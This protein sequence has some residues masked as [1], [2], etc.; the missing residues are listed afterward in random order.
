MPLYFWSLSVLP[1]TPMQ[2]PYGCKGYFKNY[3]ARFE[4]FF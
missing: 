1:F 3:F 4:M 2:Q